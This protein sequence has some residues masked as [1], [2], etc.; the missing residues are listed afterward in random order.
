M[1]SSQLEAKGLV[2]GLFDFSFSTFITLKFLRVIYGLLMALIVLFG[3]L[4]FAQ[5]ASQGGTAFLFALVVVPVVMFVYLVFARIY[6]ELIALFFRI[7]ENTSILVA[8]AGG[9][10]AGGMGGPMGG[11]GPTGGPMGGG[12]PEG[13]TTGYGYGA[14]PQ[15]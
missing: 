13:P 2:A 15:S 8:Q 12:G 10:A 3:L 14:P 9:Q 11:G 5:T 6:M 1:P 7:G 4:F